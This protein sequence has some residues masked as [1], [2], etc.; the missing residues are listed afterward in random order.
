MG[1]NAKHVW[2]DGKF[3]SEAK[4]SVPVTT[5]A[6]HY[7]TS[8]FEGIRAYWNSEN[9]Y[10]FRLNEHIERFRRSGQY[11]SISL[12]FSDSEISD[13]IIELCRK[14]KMMQACY[15]RPFYFVGQYGISL[16]VTEKSP[17]HLAM[18]VL[19]LGDLFNKRGISARISSWRKFSDASTPTQAKTGG[20]YLNS[21]I[22]TQEAKAGGFDE[23]ILLDIH[24]NVS[25]ASGANV[26]TVKNN[27]LTT[28]PISSSAL[29][30]ITRNSVLEF[31]KDLGYKTSVKKF[32]KQSLYNADEVFMTGTAAEITP[33]VKLDGKKIGSGK[34]G[35]TTRELTEEYK[36][37]T[38]N[39]NPK[40]SHWLTK[41]YGRNQR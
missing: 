20:N 27:T 25:E 7:G 41:V 40:Y 33:I 11:Y 32:K 13:A 22:A 19:P 5:H 30:G 21:I 36:K 35:S 4:A 24:G 8:V 12:N 10:V 15:I 9:L 23:A 28:P 31:A 29:N 6:I 38:S 16:H 26:F 1:T 17:T 18:F 34:P 2:F 3:M 37:I 39:Q 14:N